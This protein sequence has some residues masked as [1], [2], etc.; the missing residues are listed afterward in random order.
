VGPIAFLTAME[1]ENRLIEERLDEPEDVR[2]GSR[3]L[4]TGVLAGHRVIIVVSGIGKVAAA[5]TATL[6][7]DRF[8]PP[9]VVFCGVAGGIATEVDIGDVVIAD[10]LVQHDFDARPIFDR[11]VIPSLGTA[12]IPTDP[13]LSAALQDAATR[14]VTG[15]IE[16][17]IPPESLRRFGIERP[18]VHTGLVASGDRFIDHIAAAAELRAELP[19]TLAVEMEGAAVAQVCAERGIPFAALR[20]ISDRS[21]HNAGVDFLDYIATVAAPLTAGIIAM[22]TAA[23]GAEDPP[24]LRDGIASR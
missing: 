9:A 7:L 22:F 12:T 24:W 16:A 14:Y 2:T 17:D 20:S 10:S 19:G 3:R 21:D 5:A 1:Q 4:V 18:R 13:R 23:V 6:V 11:Y 15:A 8:D